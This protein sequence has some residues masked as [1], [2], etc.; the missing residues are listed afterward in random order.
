[1]VRHAENPGDVLAIVGTED[2][3]TP[4]ADVEELKASGVQVVEYDGAGHGFVHDPARPAHR[5]DDAADAWARFH[6]HLAID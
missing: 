6:A 2:H 1:L 5:P 3:Y 4:P